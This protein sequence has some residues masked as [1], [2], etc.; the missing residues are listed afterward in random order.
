MLDSFAAK[1]KICVI[2]LGYVGLPL[3]V[4]LS[5]KYAVI[6]FDIDASRIRELERGFDRT[7]ELPS[8][9]VLE[10][11]DLHFTHCEENLRDSNVYMLQFLLRLINGNALTYVLWLMP[12]D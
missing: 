1:S 10:S 9:F 8:E 4:A 12:V 2:G 3:A 6:G 5:K 11:A 7:N